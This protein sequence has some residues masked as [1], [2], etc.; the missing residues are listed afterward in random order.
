[1]IKHPTQNSQHALLVTIICAVDYIDDSTFVPVLGTPS[2]SRGCFCPPLHRREGDR[3][4][5]D[6]PMYVRN[7]AQFEFRRA[8]NTI[9]NT[10]EKLFI[11]R[12]RKTEWHS[13]LHTTE[14]HLQYLSS[15]DDERLRR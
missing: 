9:Q 8:A 15:V 2:H 12:F 1:M 14:L 11:H 4:Q 5:G 10:L 7:V 13:S 3:M 6:A